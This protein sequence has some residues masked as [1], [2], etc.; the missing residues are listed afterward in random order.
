MAVLMRL[1][2]QIAAKY[3]EACNAQD[4]CHFVVLKAELNLLLAQENLLQLDAKK[5]RLD[6]AAL[7]RPAPRAASVIDGI[8]KTATSQGSKSSHLYPRARFRRLWDPCLKQ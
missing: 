1:Y 4:A 7:A 8:E 3:Q 6:I 5:A 2:G